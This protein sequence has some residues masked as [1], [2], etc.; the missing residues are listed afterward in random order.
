MFRQLKGRAYQEV[1]ERELRQ[2]SV[3]DIIPLVG[4]TEQTHEANKHPLRHPPCSAH[5]LLDDYEDVE[6]AYRDEPGY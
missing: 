2:L 3:P 1:K 5:G 6:R 4:G